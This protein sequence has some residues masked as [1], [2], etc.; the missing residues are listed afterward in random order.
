MKKLKLIIT[1]S[2][3]NFILR[4]YILNENLYGKKVIEQLGNRWNVLVDE[5][6]ENKLAIAGLWRDKFGDI[7]KI[8][9]VD[10]LDNKF[11]EW[12][13]RFIDELLKTTDFVDNEETAKIYLNGF[14]KNIKSLKDKAVKVSPKN[15]KKYVDGH[16][17]WV[18]TEIRDVDIY[19]PK[20]ED[21]LFENDEIVILD[22][23]TREKCVIYGKGE[24]WCI[25]KTTYNYYNT[26]RIEDNASIY[27]VLQKNVKGDEHKLVIMVY[28]ND[29]YS[30]AD[31][32]NSP[33]ILRAGLK[34]DAIKWS[35]VENQIP[36]L[37][38]LKH[39]FK[40]IP[41][42]TQEIEYQRLISSIPNKLLN[43]ENTDNLS[44]QKI[45]E[46]ETEL[47]NSKNNNLKITPADLI[48]D[49]SKHNKYN[50]IPYDQLK[51]LDEKTMNSL[52]ETNFFTENSV[53]I[54]LDTLKDAP[55]DPS[56]PFKSVGEPKL[57]GLYH[58]PNLSR[59]QKN[60]IIQLKMK[61]NKLDFMDF[62][63]M[64]YE[65]KMKNNFIKHHVRLDFPAKFLKYLEPEIINN[66]IEINYF[67]HIPPNKHDYSNYY[68]FKNIT[69]KQKDR[70][71]LQRIDNK[72]L[73]DGD[74]EYMLKSS[75]P[76]SFGIE[77]WEDLII[78]LNPLTYKYMSD[79]ISFFKGYFPYLDNNEIRNVLDKIISYHKLKDGNVT[80]NQNLKKFVLYQY[81]KLENVSTEELKELA[82]ELIGDFSPSKFLRN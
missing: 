39:L 29:L 64:D 79:N 1:E 51:S 32:S 20:D 61:D 8:A 47:F 53:A 21:I 45:L 69:D 28:E 15:L 71:L 80:T 82:K 68:E 72:I 19:N 13:N 11:T 18:E 14:I 59:A 31:Q 3:R 17:N 38:G 34:E 57:L 22:T 46:K 27:F 10:E 24:Q 9:S 43:W 6:L 2:Q 73:Y 48:R 7:N 33:V 12:Y 66:Y 70:I 81:T 62:I 78:K 16:S 65:T 26:Y 40:H 54:S 35:E 25:A 30:I 74:I 50:W 23:D 75:P 37:R 60:R 76:E 41:M 58:L 55:Q 5:K 4:K 49:V 42:T 52:I 56:N 67:G 77:K 63:N 44:L 36:N